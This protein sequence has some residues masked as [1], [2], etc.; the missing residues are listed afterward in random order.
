MQATEHRDDVVCTFKSEEP[1]SSPLTELSFPKH[2]SRLNC[3]VTV[4]TEK[5]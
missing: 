5:P 2:I 4:A 3:V 1:Q